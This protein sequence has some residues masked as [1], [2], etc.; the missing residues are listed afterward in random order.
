MKTFIASWLLLAAD[1]LALRFWSVST[2][3]KLAL[4]ACALMAAGVF[5]ASLREVAK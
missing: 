1:T 2:G 4:G 5:L 3:G